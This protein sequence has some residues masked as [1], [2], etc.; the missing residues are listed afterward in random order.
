MSIAKN[1]AVD[2][3]YDVMKK[4]EQNFKGSLISFKVS[5]KPTHEYE[6]PIYATIDSLTIVQLQCCRQHVKIKPMLKMCGCY[7]PFCGVK[8]FEIE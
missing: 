5:D 2:S 3:V 1:K 7:C 8:S 6:T 4:W